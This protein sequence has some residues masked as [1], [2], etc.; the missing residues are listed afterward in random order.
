MKLLLDQDVYYKTYKLL[1]DNE[2]DVITAKSLGLEKAPDI[3]ILERAEKLSRILITRDKN[4]GSLVFLSK[5]STYGVIFLRIK[6]D[7]IY[8]V[9][10]TLLRFLSFHSGTKIAGHFVTIERDKYR[11]RNIPQ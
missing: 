3:Q 9:H 11:I 6:P 10:R 8:E 7:S 5:F 1:I 2:Y 4:F